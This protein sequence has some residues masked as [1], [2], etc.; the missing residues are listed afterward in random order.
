LRGP[1]PNA[2]AS[3]RTWR[4]PPIGLFDYYTMV[5]IGGCAALFLQSW[6]IR[7]PGSGSAFYR[8]AAFSVLHVLLWF[9]IRLGSRNRAIA[10]RLSSAFNSDRLTRNFC[11]GRWP[12]TRLVFFLPVAPDCPSYCFAN[13]ALDL[14]ANICSVVDWASNLLVLFVARD[15]PLHVGFLLSCSRVTGSWVLGHSTSASPSGI[16]HGFPE[17]PGS[18]VEDLFFSYGMDSLLC[19]FLTLR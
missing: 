1:A 19:L 8:I 12:T 17:F 3:R 18:D 9:L 14:S 11:L 7:P 6:L 4:P 16:L 13:R 5:N 10:W 15:Q 2:R